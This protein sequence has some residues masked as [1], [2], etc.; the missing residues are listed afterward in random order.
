VASELPQDQNRT[1]ARWTLDRG[2]GIGVLEV[3][4]KGAFLGIKYAIPAMRQTGGG[5]IVNISSMAGSCGP[6]LWRRGA[7]SD[8]IHCLPIC[9]RRHTL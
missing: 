8:K 6:R 9:E 7:Q 4:A 2:R 3:N 5:S 1:V